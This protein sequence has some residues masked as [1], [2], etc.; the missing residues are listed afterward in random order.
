VSEADWLGQA[1]QAFVAG[2][3]AEPEGDNAWYYYQRVLASD[4][5]NPVALEGVQKV[6]SYL[7]GRAETALSSNDWVDA[8][9]Q[10]ELVIALD[11]NNSAANAVIRRAGRAADI[12]RLLDR[13]VGL[14][15]AGRLVQPASGNALA[16]YRRIL[17]LSPNHVRAQQGIENIAQRLTTM[18]QS[19]ILAGN[20]GRANEL[21]A[22][23]K[24]IAPD[25]PGIA[26]TEAF[27]EQ[28]S[29]M[30]K[31]QA[32]KTE[33]IA[34]ARA[35]QD[36]NLTGASSASSTDSTSF[37]GA[38]ALEHYQAVLASDPDSD[39]ARS[40]VQLVINT[41]LERARE[42]VALD[43]LAQA[44][45]TLEQARLAGASE[46]QREPLMAELDF[47]R[48]RARARAGEFTRVLAISELEFKK[49]VQPV[50][51]KNATDGSVELL[52]TVNEQGETADMEIVESSDPALE[53]A[54]LNAVA[55]W[56][57]APYL[58]GGRPI[59]VRSGIRFTFQS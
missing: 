41:L 58:D 8:R 28:W 10:A 3:V 30:A 43:Q 47:M 11:K 21:M 1:D 37:N 23:A 40:G 32:V 48:R 18:A 5:Q 56:R 13:A 19:E 14:V 50:S 27:T 51:P 36:G 57:F 42:F 46:L 59:P 45:D 39:A 49:Q 24:E 25:A 17:T 54:A 15:A 53:A 2:R 12:E 33:L 34:A 44:A 35:L 20:H 16:T 55:R 29:D 4:P 31:D 9:Q 38:S 6:V 52:F 26:Q 22:Q 7:V